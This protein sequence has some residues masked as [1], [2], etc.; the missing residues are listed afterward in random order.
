MGWG[1]GSLLMSSVIS[2]LLKKG[3]DDESRKAVYE[4]LIPAM[5]MQDWDTETECMC[6]DAAYDAT[7]KKLKPHW[8]EDDAD[9]PG[10]QAVVV[11]DSDPGVDIGQYFPGGMYE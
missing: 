3:I 6:E 4:V 11:E 1:S 5:Q 2:G 9:L 8:F 7:L 10:S